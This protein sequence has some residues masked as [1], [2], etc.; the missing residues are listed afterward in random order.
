MLVLST[1]APPGANTT[2]LQNQQESFM[3][4]L[5]S[6]H[7]P[8]LPWFLFPVSL[9]ATSLSFGQLA[10]TL[11]PSLVLTLLLDRTNGR[12][13]R[14]VTCVF[15]YITRI[16]SR[17]GSEAGYNEGTLGTCVINKRS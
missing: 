5:R 9:L 14:A 8:Q 15:R 13:K 1:R 6:V 10:E 7:W 16:P 17:P 3:Q 11:A 12:H 4:Q 2:G